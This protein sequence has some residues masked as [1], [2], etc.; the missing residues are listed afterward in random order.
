[1]CGFFQKACPVGHIVEGPNLEFSMEIHQ[2]L[3]HN[4]GKCLKNGA[5]GEAKIMANIQAHYLCCGRPLP[6][7]PENDDLVS[8]QPFLRVLPFRVKGPISSPHMVPSWPGSAHSPPSLHPN[9]SL[10]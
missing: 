1:M 7:G 5:S 6:S 3:L 9:S 2:E 8:G 10:P 4:G